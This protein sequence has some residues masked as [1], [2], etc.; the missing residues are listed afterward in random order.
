MGP[1]KRTRGCDEVFWC[2]VDVQSP[3][4]KCESNLLWFVRFLGRRVLEEGL[5]V[6][7][8]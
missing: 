6:V 3:S 1:G 8:K 5:S 2:G 7:R 4:L